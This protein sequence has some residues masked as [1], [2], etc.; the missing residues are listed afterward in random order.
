[1]TRFEYLTA[2]R[3]ALEGLPP[4]VIER[5]LAACE[6][7]IHE[8]SAAGRSEDEILASLEDP[9]KV[10]DDLRA[11]HAPKV[12]AVIS[13]APSQ[14]AP[15]LRGPVSALRMFFSLIGLSV[16]NL[17]L[18]GPAIAYASLLIAAFAVSLACYAAG[19][20][21]TGASLSG[22]NQVALAGPFHHVYFDKPEQIA[23]LRHHDGRTT[24][25]IGETGIHVETGDKLIHVVPSTVAATQA[26]APSAGASAASAAA[27]TPATDHNTVVDISPNGVIVKDGGD[28]DVKASDDDVDVDLPGLHIHNSDVDVDHGAVSLG[29]DFISESQSVQVGVGIGIIFTGVIG[30]LLCLT[31]LRYTWM[32]VLKLAQLEFG[33]LR[34]A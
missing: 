9:Q 27:S 2:L 1:M 3:S 33:V 8:A 14:N 31:I 24:V 5:T 21:I 20:A 18:I 4:E 16:F 15:A 19:I 34:G 13:A 11:E 7:R 22:V 17:F 30:F 29:T 25:N 23:D 12:P 26:G 28:R 10:A 6:Q 32:G